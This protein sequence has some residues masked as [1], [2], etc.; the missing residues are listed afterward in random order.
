[1]S[2]SVVRTAKGQLITDDQAINALNIE[3]SAQWF[4]PEYW[5]QQQAIVNTAHGRGIT[6]FIKYQS[7][8]MVLRRYLRGGLIRHLS[9]DKFVFTGLQ[10]TRAWQ[11]LALLNSMNQQGLAVPQGIAGMVQ[12][13][14]LVYT[15]SILTLCLP[16]TDSLHNVLVKTELSNEQWQ[17]IG[18]MVKQFH[19]AQIYHHDM[20]VHNFLRNPEG[21]TWLID[22]DKCKRQNGENW[23]QDNLNR[24][25]RSLN[26]EKALAD[27][28]QF[29]NSHWNAFLNGYNR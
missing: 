19:D 28:Y 17:H 5:Q 3:P 22:F 13:Q 20:N 27:D 11:E 29:E 9:K 2:L 12:K 7:H 10:K 14:G 25:L 1:M 15:T 4:S 21:K 24:F 23:K 18:I 8:T 6:Y 26:K 16:N